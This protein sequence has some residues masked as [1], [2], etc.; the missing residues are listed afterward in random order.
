MPCTKSKPPEL[1]VEDP[2]KMSLRL[3][4]MH[5]CGSQQI[6]A[7][8]TMHY[9]QQSWFQSLNCVDVVDTQCR[10]LFVLVTTLVAFHFPMQLICGTKA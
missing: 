4:H 9:F 5:G 3:W 1:R 2:D 7:I 6:V 10:L 8:V